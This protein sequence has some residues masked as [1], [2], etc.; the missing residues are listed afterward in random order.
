[1]SFRSS[2]I[3]LA[4]WSWT[5]PVLV[6]VVRFREVSPLSVCGLLLP[7]LSGSDIVTHGFGDLVPTPL[8]NNDILGLLSLII[9]DRVIIS[10]LSIIFGVSVG[11]RFDLKVGVRPLLRCA[12][13]ELPLLVDPDKSLALL[14]V[15]DGLFRDAHA[16]CHPYGWLDGGTK[17]PN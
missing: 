15:R 5:P 16:C 9:S 13:H 4:G 10:L 3:D 6:L 1:M 11:L 12:S 17:V 2:L 8:Y 14:G 7:P